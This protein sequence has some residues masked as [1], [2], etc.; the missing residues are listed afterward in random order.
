MRIDLKAYARE[1]EYWLDAFAPFVEHGSQPALPRLKEQLEN[2]RDVARPTFPWK[3]DKPVM[4]IAADKYDGVNK[5][6]HQ[7]RIG[8]QFTA[9]FKSAEIQRRNALW[10]I[11]KMETHIYVRLCDSG[12]DILHFHYDLKNKGQLGPHVHMQLSEHFQKNKGLIPIAVPRFPS[13]AVLPTDCLDLVLAEFFPFKWP[14]SQKDSRGLSTLQN[15]Q[16]KRFMAM[17][18]AI[19]KGW[20]GSRKTPIA[21]IQECFLPDFQLV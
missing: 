2:G 9:I 16:Q 18:Q 12:N 1:L 14:Q 17:S 20:Q 13:A 19:A 7:V 11:E 21:A 10:T 5:T 4:T 8:W 3:L 6:P 15:G